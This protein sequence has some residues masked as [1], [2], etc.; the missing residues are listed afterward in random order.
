MSNLAKAVKILGFTEFA[1]FFS[2]SPLLENALKFS[3]FRSNTV[4]PKCAESQISQ[5]VWLSQS[6]C[7]S[8]VFGKRIAA[9]A[10]CYERLLL[11][12][13]VLGFSVIAFGV[14]KL[15]SSWTALHSSWTASLCL[16]REKQVW[17][18]TSGQVGMP[19]KTATLYSILITSVA[20]ALDC[21]G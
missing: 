16:S 7:C 3:V 4:Q 13:S 12:T 6:V 15:P 19:A 5:K 20:L 11:T 9:D 1:F 21:L 18:S 8:Y 14:W 2:P 10:S 17:S